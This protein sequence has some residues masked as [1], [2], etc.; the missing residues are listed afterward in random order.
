MMVSISTGGFTDLCATEVAKRFYHEGIETVE[1][2]G[3]LFDPFLEKHLLELKAMGVRFVFH[4]YFPVPKKSLVVNLA[5]LD[6]EIRKASIKHLKNAIILSAKYGSRVYG[7]HAGFLF[8]PMPKLLGKKMP[9]VKLQERERG[10]A[11]FIDGVTDILKVADSEGVN[12]LIEN[13]VLSAKNYDSF[14]ENPFL[15]A[16]PTEIEEI[17]SAF[18]GKVNLL[19]DVAHLKVSAKSLNFPLFLV[20]EK[21]SSYIHACHL[22]DNSGDADE[23]APVTEKSWFWEYLSKLKLT[24]LSLEVYNVSYQALREQRDLVRKSLTSALK[25]LDSV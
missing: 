16:D 1:L 8:D 11:S 22:S 12:L 19:L 6:P 13:N 14:G 18:S 20:F 17:L 25:S 23:N 9:R 15:M 4:H 3:G 24:Y 10:K 21:C 7:F 5:S 2:S